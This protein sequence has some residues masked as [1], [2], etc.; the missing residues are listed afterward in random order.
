MCSKVDSEYNIAAFYKFTEMSGLEVLKQRLSD[1][2]E[3][4]DVLG[5]IIIA[6]EGYNGTIAAKPSK[7]AD[8]F[9]ELF[10]ILNSKTEIKISVYSEPGFQRRKV[11]IKKEIVALKKPVKIELGV[12]THVG[13]DDWNRII[14]DSGTILID[15]RND[16]EFRAGTFKGAINPETE[17][18]S[19]LP[20]FIESTLKPNKDKTIAMFCTGGIRCEKLAPYLVEQGFENIVQLDGGILRYLDEVRADASL[21]E[22]ECFVFDERITLDHELGKGK[23]PDYS[24]EKPASQKQK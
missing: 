10:R 18:F 19:E 12:G 20:Q 22:G 6:D 23:T 8:F 9:E 13:V 16:Y 15:A 1:C 4:H 3:A 11:K 2:M 21:W 7:F 17:S 24:S 5:T 14:S